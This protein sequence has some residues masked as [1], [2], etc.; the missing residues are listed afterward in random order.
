MNEKFVTPHLPALILMY[1]RVATVRPD[2]FGLC[3]SPENF[4]EQMQVLREHAH[5]ISLRGLTESLQSGRIPERAVA[6]TFDDG[7]ADNLLDAKPLLVQHDVP[8]TMF[9]TTGYL[10]RP[11]EFW[12]D[13]VERHFLEP[14]ILP[15]RLSLSVCGQPHEWNLANAAQYDDDTCRQFHAWRT[16]QEP[17]TVR[18]DTYFSVW[19]ALQLIPEDERRRVLDQIQA[20]AGD[21]GA[22]PRPE[23]RSVTSDEVRKLAEG[24]LIEI[25]AHTVTHPALCEFSAAEQWEEI[26][27]SKRHLETLLGAPVTSFAYPF[28]TC[29]E[30]TIKLV[31]ESGF[32]RACATIPTAITSSDPNLYELPRV[33]VEDW[34]GTTFLQRL[35]EWFEAKT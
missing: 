21:T 7:Y 20:W 29:S 11:R 9:I 24:G 5:P 23:Y 33:Q 25:G 14:G 34:S 19:R 2:P 13:E 12:W 17:P 18:H 32:E 3:V 22:G 16:E 8:A 4:A 15:D 31:Q 27:Q 6:V 10:E 28:G 30:P 26:T 1:H 35:E